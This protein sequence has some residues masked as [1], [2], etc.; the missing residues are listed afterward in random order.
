MFVSL[1]FNCS[2]H[3]THTSSKSSMQNE[4]TQS[5]SPGRVMFKSVPIVASAFLLEQQERPSIEAS[6]SLSILSI[7]KQ[8]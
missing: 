4:M 7:H 3:K 2:I 1:A 5:L 6:S 8:I